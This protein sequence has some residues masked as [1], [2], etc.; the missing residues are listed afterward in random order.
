MIRGSASCDLGSAKHVLLEPRHGVIVGL[1]SELDE[2]VGILVTIRTKYH[3]L[4]T[5]CKYEKSFTVPSISHQT[6][7]SIFS[8][9]NCPY[10][11]LHSISGTALPEAIMAPLVWLITGAS[12]GLGLSLARAVLAAGHKVIATSR[13]PENSAVEAVELEKTSNAAWMKLDVASDQ[14]EQQ[15]Q[16][17]AEKF[18]RIDVLVNNAG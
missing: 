1:V 17:C 16:A 18:G 10:S 14:L 11:I 7:I 8:R 15:L 6:H 4:D 12:S 3:S 5:R 9:S 13:K 2:S